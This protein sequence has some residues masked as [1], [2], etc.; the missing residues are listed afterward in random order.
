MKVN[1][2]EADETCQPLQAHLFGFF[3]QAYESDVN[4]FRSLAEQY[5]NA[6]EKA[7]LSHILSSA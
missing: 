6:E 1:Q 7:L 4:Q 3:R 5:L 2:L